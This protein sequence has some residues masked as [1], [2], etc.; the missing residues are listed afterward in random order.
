MSQTMITF[1]M[2]QELKKSME[3]TCADM[4]LTMTAAFTIFAKKVVRERRIPFEVT[5]GP[6]AQPAPDVSSASF[7]PFDTVS[8]AVETCGKNPL[9]SLIPP[10][11]H[12]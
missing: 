3:Q 2:D 6:A 9:S 10:D 7:A 12:H 4:G 11:Y 8:N 1:R 5:A